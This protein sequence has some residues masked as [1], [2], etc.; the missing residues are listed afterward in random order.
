MKQH[1]LSQYQKGIHF[2]LEYR[3]ALSLTD[4][5]GCN[6]RNHLKTLDEYY[7]I[8]GAC[9]EAGTAKL[10]KIFLDDREKEGVQRKARRVILVLF[11]IIAVEAALLLFTTN[12][13]MESKFRDLF[14]LA[15]VIS[16]LKLLTS[17][18]TKHKCVHHTTNTSLPYVPYVQQR[19]GGRQRKRVLW[20]I[21]LPPQ[22]QIPASLL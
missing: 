18:A 7:F 12:N 19:G 21:T 9:C 14:D 17:S 8:K 1:S 3:S 22:H 2:A 13:P 5:F 15:T 20:G 10:T 6:K 4:L 16:A 11:V